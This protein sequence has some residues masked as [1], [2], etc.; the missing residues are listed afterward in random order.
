MDYPT[1][2]V[3]YAGSTRQDADGGIFYIVDQDG[4]TNLKRF[5]DIPSCAPNDE[6]ACHTPPDYSNRAC[7]TTV[8][9]CP[10][11]NNSVEYCAESLG[12]CVPVGT[13]GAVDDCLNSDNDGQ[14]AVVACDGGMM[15]CQNGY[16]SMNCNPNE[17]NT[18]ATATNER[19]EEEENN[20]TANDE[21]IG[22][23]M[24]TNTT[25]LTNTT[26]SMETTTVATETNTTTDTSTNTTTTTDPSDNDASREEGSLMTV[27]YSTNE[28]DE[29]D[30]PLNKTEELDLFFD[31]MNEYYTTNTDT[32]NITSNTDST[33]A[34]N[35][36]ET[37]E[38]YSASS[39]AVTL[40]TTTTLPTCFATTLGVVVV[41]LC[42][43]W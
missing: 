42:S 15:E 31:S 41:A 37:S 29:D 20:D 26:Q 5:A 40:T 35:Q 13:C 12:L 27:S 10:Q 43:A 32:T 17:S 25:T 24:G 2:C 39:A 38:Q 28:E 36:L 11:L 19:E 34:I 4:G 18:N 23:E 33:L 6:N 21:E 30:K 16:C 9:D 7:T 1:Y 14:Y 8:D 3:K 22:P